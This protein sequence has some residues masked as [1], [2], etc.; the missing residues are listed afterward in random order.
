M[1]P[2]QGR[3]RNVR[4][5]WERDFGGFAEADNHTAEARRTHGRAALG[6]EDVAAVPL[7][8]LQAT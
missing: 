8:A 1:G 3:R 6:Q 5:H 2:A 4:V 7:F